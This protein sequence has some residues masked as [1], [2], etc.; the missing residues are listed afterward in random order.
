[1]QLE[2]DVKIGNV[3]DVDFEIVNDSIE[4]KVNLAASVAATGTKVGGQISVEQP[5]QPILD[6]LI[7]KLPV[8]GLQSLATDIEKALLALGAGA[9]APA[10]VTPAILG[11]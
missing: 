10:A 1:M 7:A 6:K 4:I 5:L 11:A 3:G 2:K 8:G 9:A